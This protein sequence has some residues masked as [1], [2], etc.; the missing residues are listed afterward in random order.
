MNYMELI[1]NHW[2]KY[3]SITSLDAIKEYGITR[4]SAVIYDLRH[5]GIEIQSVPETV[6]NRYGRDCHIVRYVLMREK[7]E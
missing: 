6:V 4:L 1:L 7:H 2:R 3:R 5:N